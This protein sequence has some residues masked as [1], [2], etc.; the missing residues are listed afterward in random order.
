MNTESKFTKFYS[1]SDFLKIHGPGRARNSEIWVP[2][3][4]G[5]C[6][7][8]CF[9]KLRVKLNENWPGANCPTI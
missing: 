5:R 6:Q 1:K 3:P 4:G 9:L 2:G 7:A 8:N